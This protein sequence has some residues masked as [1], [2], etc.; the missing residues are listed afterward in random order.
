MAD[1]SCKLC[2]PVPRESLGLLV[3]LTIAFAGAWAIELIPVRALGYGSLKTGSAVQFWLI[4]VMYVPMLAALVARKVEGCGFADAGLGWGRGRY[5]LVAWLFP[6][7]LGVVATVLTLALGLGSYDPSLSTIMSRVPPEGQE[8]VRQQ[9][10]RFGAWLPVIIWVSAL[11]QAVLINCVATFGEEFGWRGYMQRRLE[12]FGVRAS[13]L[14][15]GLIWGVWHAPIVAQGHNYPGHAALGVPLFIVFCVVWSVILGWLRNA[16]GSVWA[17]TIA[18]ASMNGPAVAPMM[19]VRGA[20]VLVAN[21]VGVIGIVLAG[22]FAAYLLSAGLIRRPVDQP[23][24][25]ET[26][27]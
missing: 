7:V 2:R 23:P 18:H 16:S 20:N 9:T 27:S 11:T 8:F 3:Y 26:E 1:E 17:P 15:T 22:L 24:V 5:H 4:G 10:A 6:A 13:V 12:R 25:C 19:L 14:L 21:F